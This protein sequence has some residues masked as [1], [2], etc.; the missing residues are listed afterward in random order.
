MD[1]QSAH[2]INL[3]PVFAPIY[4][5]FILSL[6]FT[7]M[8]IVQAYV[9][10]PSHGDKQYIRVMAGLMLFLDLASS[11]LAAQSIYYYLVPYFGSLVPLGAITPELSAECLVSTIIT[12]ISQGYFIYQLIIVK[13]AGRGSWLVISTITFFQILAFGGG[14]GCVA[15]MYVFKHGVLSDR[16]ET[17][18]IFFGL[19]KGAGAM[20]DILATIAMCLFLSTVRTGISR[21]NETLRSLI[22]FVVHRGA[23]VTL[24]QV[25]LLITFYS[26]PTKLVWFAFHLNVTK[27]YANTFFAMLNARSSLKDRYASG[28]G[29]SSNNLHLNSKTLGSSHERAGFKEGTNPFQQFEPSQMPRVSKTVVVTTV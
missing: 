18:S 4:W 20:T 16:N 23:L 15:T 22:R 26:S 5:G 12:S 25:L 29:I 2:G 27:L 3:G 6:V 9:Y 8:T 11:A 21:T 10:F 13:R 24:V 14:L 7:G 19:A 1:T 17:F 28:V